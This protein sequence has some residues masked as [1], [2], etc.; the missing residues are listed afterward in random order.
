[1]RPPSTR[2]SA[3]RREPT[4]ATR[5]RSSHFGDRSAPFA[6]LSPEAGRTDDAGAATAAEA[7]AP[8]AL[9]AADIELYERGLRKEI[10]LVRAAQAAAGSATTPEARSQAMQ[11]QRA[12]QTM[13][14]AA[15]SLGVAPE[16][17]RRVRETL[18]E[19]LET[20]DFQGRIEGPM[21]MDTTR[22]SPEARARLARAAM[23]ELPP[24]TVAALRARLDRLAPI[25]AQYVTLTAVGG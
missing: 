3:E 5:P 23:A 7:D 17:Y 19:V 20:L 18:H 8:V 21:Q 2:P 22:A 11:A 9:D 15:R 10:E 4:I 13:P 12:E 6:H 25:F 16:R 1:M 14:E 24:A